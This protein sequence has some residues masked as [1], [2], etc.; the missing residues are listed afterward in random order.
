MHC[1]V[2]LKKIFRLMQIFLLVPSN[3]YL[4]ANK[5][6]ACRQLLDLM[7]VF[8][9]ILTTFVLSSPFCVASHAMVTP[10]IKLPFY[11]GFKSVEFNLAQYM[12]TST[13]LRIPVDGEPFWGSSPS[14]S[15]Q[16]SSSS[17]LGY[18]R[19]A[20]PSWIIG[21]WPVRENKLLTFHY[22]GIRAFGLDGIV[23]WWP[24]LPK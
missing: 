19:P 13:F 16:P 22:S 3:R 21:W 2:F 4:L 24:D 17:S 7:L 8:C 10:R 15:S 11:S 12:T 23:G 9:N 5:G 18:S 6:A 20:W 1:K 14:L